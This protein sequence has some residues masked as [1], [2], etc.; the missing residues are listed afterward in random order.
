MYFKIEVLHL[1]HAK[2]ASF[3]EAKL[4]LGLL[5][6][7]V[8]DILLLES[9]SVVLAKTKKYLKRHF[10]T[11]DIRKLKYFLGIKVAYQKHGLFLSQRKYALNLLKETGL[12][13]Y[14][15]TSTPIESNV[16]IWYDGSHPLD[17]PRHY[18]RLIEKLIY[19]TFTRLDITF[20]V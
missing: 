14:K 2:L 7:Y 19:L 12:L 16:N 9:D 10:V 13:G 8:D 15:T 6:V 3:L 4:C 11:K 20:A 1:L 18:R 17:D 5:A